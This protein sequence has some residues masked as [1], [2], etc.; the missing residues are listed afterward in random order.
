MKHN[1]REL[2]NL[3]P[4]IQNNWIILLGGGSTKI[5]GFNK[6]DLR[7]SERENTIQT[8]NCKASGGLLPLYYSL[9]YSV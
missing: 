4:I 9:L 6:L 1:E 2:L 5:L 3:L 7:I 8:T